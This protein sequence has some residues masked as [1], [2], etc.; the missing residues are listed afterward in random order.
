MNNFIYILIYA[1]NFLTR[2][3]INIIINYFNFRGILIDLE[4]LSTF[5]HYHYFF[6]QLLSYFQKGF[7]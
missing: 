6:P 5:L 3:E 1:I 4:K 7:R 2:K